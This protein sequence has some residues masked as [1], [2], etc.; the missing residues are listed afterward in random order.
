MWCKKLQHLDLAGSIVRESDLRVLAY[1]LE[2]KSLCLPR[3]PDRLYEL[4]FNAAS[5]SLLFL[6]ADEIENLRAQMPEEFSRLYPKYLDLRAR[7]DD[8]WRKWKGAV[9][10]VEEGMKVFLSGLGGVDPTAVPP[11]IARRAAA[12]A[13]NMNGA[14]TESLSLLN[15]S[16]RQ[17]VSAPETSFPVDKN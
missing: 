16:A 12:V 14:Q 9:H 5:K 15:K 17:K 1:G 7:V 2:P 6:R 13:I 3:M 4:F 10:L 8:N 11:D